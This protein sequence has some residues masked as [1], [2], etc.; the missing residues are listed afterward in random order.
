MAEAPA[1]RHRERQKEGEPSRRGGETQTVPPQEESA[2][3][4]VHAHG[5]EEEVGLLEV[6]REDDQRYH[7]R[8]AGEGPQPTSRQSPLRGPEQERR[9]GGD[10][11]LPV[12]AG[13]D[14]GDHEGGQEVGQA[15][16]GGPPHGTG[17]GPGSTRR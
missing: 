2:D 11:E 7:Q 12:M 16:T 9:Q 14:Q 10:E 17:P 3:E 13:K 1:P 5:S 6:G 15:R 8:H 4:G